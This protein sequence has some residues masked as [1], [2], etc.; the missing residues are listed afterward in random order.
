MLALFVSCTLIASVVDGQLNAV[1]GHDPYPVSADA[2]GLHAE[3]T[4]VDL[5]ADSLLWQRS[6]L[7]RNERGHVDLPRLQEGGVAL[8]VFTA[9]TKTP[10]DM[11]YDANSDETDNI[12]A[13]ARFQGWP[14]ATHDSLLERALYQGERLHGYAAASDELVV[15]TTAAELDELLARRAAGEPLVGGLLGIEGGHAIEGSLEG[16][17][18]LHA[19]G[20]RYVGLTHFFDNELGGSAHGVEQGGLTELGRQVVAELAELGMV[21]DLAHASPALFSEVLA[22][23][24]RPVVVSHTGV[25][26]THDSPRN[27]SD[28]QLRGVAATGGVVG[29]GYWDGAVGEASLPAIVAAMTYVKDL[30]GVEHVAL[31]SDFDGTITAP[32]DTSELPALT[33]ALLEAGWTAE[34]VSAA[35]GGNA[36]RVFRAVL[37]G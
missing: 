31:G 29:V 37:P 17:R 24:S 11:N 1:I 5:H 15:V 30:V 4:V 18:A 32:L 20:F 35:M 9:V 8:Q 2:R 21:V 22:A 36:V 13:L 12:T 23:T 26:G 19:A 10:K 6:L 27:L 33:H 34:E 3:L 7:E 16:L 25:K 14:A 28:E